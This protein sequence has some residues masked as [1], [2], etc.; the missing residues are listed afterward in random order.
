MHL[1][2]QR[3]RSR[4]DDGAGVEVGVDVCSCRGRRGARATPRRRRGA[5]RSSPRAS[6]DVD[7]RPVWSCMMMSRVPPVSIAAIGMPRAPASSR[8]RLSD[9]GPCEGNTSTAA[10]ASQRRR[11]VAIEPAGEADVAARG[12]RVG[13]DRGAIGPSPTITSG[14]A[15]FARVDRGH[16][17]GGA[18]VRRELADVERVRRR[19]ERG[20]GRRLR[21][22]LADRA[23]STGLGIDLDPRRR[24][25]RRACAQV[26]RDGRC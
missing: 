10:C 15:R 23:T 9:S 8:T 6:A 11:C 17:L 4:G 7:S 14:Q 3:D 21:G 26:A 22:G 19:H 18:F 24:Q 12:A 16:Q 13:L 25:F 1:V 2:V 20:G 5:A